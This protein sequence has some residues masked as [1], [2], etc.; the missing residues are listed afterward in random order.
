MSI[1]R[2][3]LSNIKDESIILVT[4]DFLKESAAKLKSTKACKQD[5]S[6]HKKHAICHGIP[7]PLAGVRVALQFRHLCHFLRLHRA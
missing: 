3:K 1:L 2:G 4:G 7:Y 5:P 6:P